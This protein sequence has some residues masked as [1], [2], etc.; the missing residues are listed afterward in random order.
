MPFAT[1]LA[2]LATEIAH[3]RSGE[4]MLV[5]NSGRSPAQCLLPA[6]L[7]GLVLGP[8]DVVLDAWLGPASMAVQMHERLGLDG[9]RLD[10]TRR[11]DVHWIALQ[12]GL[13]STEIA[14]GP[15]PVLH[16]LTFF[17]LDARHRL[18]EIDKAA[19]ARQIPGSDLWLMRDGRFWH[20]DGGTMANLSA[21]TAI[22]SG[23]PAGK[24]MIPFTDRTV[25]LAVDPLWLSVFGMEPQY[26]PMKVLRALAWGDARGHSQDLY[27]TRLDTLY[28]EAVL[29]GAMAVLAATLSML[30]LAYAT[31]PGALAGIVFAG[32]L[33]HAAT[34][35]CL[36][37]G[38]NGVVP[39]LVAGWFVPLVLLAGSWVAFRV[40]GF[41]HRE[42]RR[43]GRPVSQ[44][45]SSG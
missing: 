26:L 12:G 21:E 4:R 35:A 1:F 13:L 38:E 15:P 45:L 19:E 27:R 9:K 8:A 16:N 33:A 44:P 2:V 14:Y 39:P 23:D 3:T 6:I 24:A 43:R 11:D 7:L 29:P 42:T 10:R 34:K 22:S 18:T 41:A 40:F 30:L 17:Q 20:A 31:P 37:M 25:R 28:G 32:Y 5:W 36:L